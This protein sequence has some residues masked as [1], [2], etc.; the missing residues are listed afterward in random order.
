ML[1]E[2]VDTKDLKNTCHHKN[3]HFSAFNHFTLNLIIITLKEIVIFWE[4]AK[5]LILFY[6]SMIVF[7]L[8]VQNPFRAWTL[9][10]SSFEK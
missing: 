9:L 6:L 8:F 5:L 10:S 7:M 4:A 3:K 1:S 2:T